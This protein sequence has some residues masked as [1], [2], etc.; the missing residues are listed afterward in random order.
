MSNDVADYYKKLQYIQKC[1]VNFGYI[2]F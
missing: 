1:F 2:S